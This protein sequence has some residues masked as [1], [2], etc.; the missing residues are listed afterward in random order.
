MPSASAL[1]EPSPAP[2][3]AHAPG[4]SVPR[5]LG[6]LRGRAA[7][8]TLILVGSLHGNEPAGVTALLRVVKDLEDRGAGIVR[9]DLLALA[10]NL[11]A[12]ALNRRYLREDLN[13][14]WTPERVARVRAGAGTLEDEDEEL[15]ALDGEISRARLS[16]RGPVVLFDVHSMSAEGPAFVMFDDALRNRE[17]ALRLP[18][19]SVL[20]LEEELEGTLTDYCVTEGLTAFGFEAGEL[21]ASETIDRAAAAVWMVLDAVGLLEPDRWPQVARARRSLDEDRGT[22]PAVVAV[23]YR[24]P[25]TEAL[26]FRMLPGFTNFQV[27]VEGQPLA[28]STS[29]PVSAPM[30][31]HIL[32]PLYQGQGSDGFFIVRPVHAGWLRVSAIVRRLPVDHLLAWLPGVSRHPTLPGSFVIDTH[33]ARWLALPLF[34]LLGFKRTARLP[35]GLVMTPRGGRRG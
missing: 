26:E 21:Y 27:V 13:R 3:S 19:P 2:S 29:G 23:Q 18:C 24:H 25:I 16:A 31:G 7:G 4:I 33:R 35:H 34:H 30:T 28:S 9:G 12:L 15:A 22:L 32:M 8:P 1:I 5:V 6:R 20:G 14:I 11:K 17:L 10:G